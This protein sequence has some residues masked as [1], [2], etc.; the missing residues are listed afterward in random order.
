MVRSYV[1]QYLGNIQCLT[2]KFSEDRINPERTVIA[3][4]WQAKYSLIRKKL[5]YQTKAG[6]ASG[7]I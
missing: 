2:T 1:S 6:F 7:F 3:A 5:V 4:F